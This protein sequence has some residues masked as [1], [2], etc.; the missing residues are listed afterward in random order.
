V[1]QR[2]IA[3]DESLKGALYS[4]LPPELRMW[5]RAQAIASLQP[6]EVPQ[7]YLAAA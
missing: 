2:L 7:G 5:M 1:L 4:D 6:D 3:D